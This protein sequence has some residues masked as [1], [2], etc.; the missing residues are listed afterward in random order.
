MDYPGS[1][2]GRQVAVCTLLALLMGFGEGVVA[3]SATP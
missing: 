1:L 2:F 3:E